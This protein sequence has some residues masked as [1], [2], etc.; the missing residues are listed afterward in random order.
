MN[1]IPISQQSYDFA[2][3]NIQYDDAAPTPYAIVAR[4]G[5]NP[6]DPNPPDP[7]EVTSTSKVKVPLGR[8]FSILLE[9]ETTGR[10]R[11]PMSPL[12]SSLLAASPSGP[13]AEPG[14]LLFPDYVVFQYEITNNSARREF[15]SVRLGT[16]PLQIQPHDTKLPTLQ[17]TISSEMP[18]S[19]GDPHTAPGGQ[20]GHQW[21]QI[22]SQQGSRR[23]I[24]PQFIKAI[25]YH[26][27][28]DDPAHPFDIH[29]WRYEPGPDRASIAGLRGASPYSL[30]RLNSP[31]ADGNY[32]LGGTSVPRRS[33]RAA[34]SS[35]T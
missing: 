31:P 12:N 1:G 10:P 21:D 24:P 2:I 30:F 11:G 32:S 28:S 20:A 4:L 35:R 14:Q 17:L 29:D 7:V 18:S 25:G 16:V 9:I 34:V 3:D 26:E 23:G 5:D 33:I 6:D 27:S 22:M 15:Q 13:A 8:S 19:L